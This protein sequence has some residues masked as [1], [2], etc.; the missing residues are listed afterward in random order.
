M[1]FGL[2]VT[3]RQPSDRASRPQLTPAINS[4]WQL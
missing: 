3:N 2:A 4:F 1:Q